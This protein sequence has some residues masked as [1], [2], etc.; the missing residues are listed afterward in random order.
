MSLDFYRIWVYIPSKTKVSRNPKIGLQY[1]I[2]KKTARAE[3]DPFAR[4]LHSIRPKVYPFGINKRFWCNWGFDD[5]SPEWLLFAQIFFI[6]HFQEGWPCTA[7]STQLL[8]A[9]MDAV[10][11]WINDLWISTLWTAAAS[12]SLRTLPE[13]RDGLDLTC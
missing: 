4:I 6:R 8:F 1:L 13:L 7:L 10:F 5:H 11:G 12:T 9:R 3:I 2:E